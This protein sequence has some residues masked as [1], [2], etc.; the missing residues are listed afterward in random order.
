MTGWESYMYES[1][2]SGDVISWVIGLGMAALILYI[3]IGGSI[4]A[5]QDRRRIERDATLAAWETQQRKAR[6]R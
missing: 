5:W 3:V 1:G 6:R 2:S 4:A